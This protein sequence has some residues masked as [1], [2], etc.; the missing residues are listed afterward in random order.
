M[1]SYSVFKV[2][3]VSGLRPNSRQAAGL[4]SRCSSREGLR[5]SLFSSTSTFHFYSVGLTYPLIRAGIPT[6]L[7]KTYGFLVDVVFDVLAVS[8]FW[9]DVVMMVVDVF[10]FLDVLVVLAL[11]V[12][13]VFFVLSVESEGMGFLDYIR[14]SVDIQ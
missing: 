3:V 8:V 13:L 9:V 11:Y 6:G 4:F 10:V 12:L 5:P 14:D 2:R 1:A 7:S